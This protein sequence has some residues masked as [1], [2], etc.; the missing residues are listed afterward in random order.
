MKSDGCGIVSEQVKWMSEQTGKEELNMGTDQRKELEEFNERYLNALEQ[1]DPQAMIDLWK[2]SDQDRCISIYGVTDG[3]ENIRRQMERVLREDLTYLH[4][5]SSEMEI[6]SL[7]EDNALV[8]A[9]YETV[10]AGSSHPQPASQQVIETRFLIRENGQWKLSCLHQSIPNAAVEKKDHENQ[11]VLVDEM[12]ELIGAGSA[13]RPRSFRD[14]KNLLENLLANLT[15]EQITPKLLELQASL[16]RMERE[17]LALTALPFIMDE[18]QNLSVWTGE[19]ARLAVDGLISFMKPYQSYDPWL[20][21]KTGL[22]LQRD[23]YY[24]RHILKEKT[25]T[26]TNYELPVKGII[27]VTSDPVFGLY[28]PPKQEAFK[29]AF[30]EAIRQA[31]KAGY[32][33]VAVLPGWRDVIHVPITQGAADLSELLEQAIENPDSS[34]QKA[35][36]ISAKNDQTRALRSAA[37]LLQTKKAASEGPDGSADH[38]ES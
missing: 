35:V 29:E 25:W 17:N 26:N 31:E 14:R 36:L 13:N 37:D 19:P 18:N 21:K 11:A 22:G 30:S 34:I 20:S 23:N 12:L 2:Q 8:Y 33:T 4:L 27:E 24:H 6:L 3:S 38:S 1:R 10:M 28:T 15:E 9:S 5:I 16:L 32:R 7:H